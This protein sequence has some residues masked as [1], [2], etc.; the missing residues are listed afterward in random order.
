MQYVK[1]KPFIDLSPREQSEALEIIQELVPEFE[2]VADDVSV[3]IVGEAVGENTDIIDTNV[4]NATKHANPKDTIE[5]LVVESTSA[6][7]NAEDIR[8]VVGAGKFVYLLVSSF[9]NINSL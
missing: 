3:E 2:P 7:A 6:G 5:A 4:E 9:A 8:R 1:E